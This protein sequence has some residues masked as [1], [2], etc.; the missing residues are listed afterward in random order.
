[1]RFETLS[2]LTIGLFGMGAEG[3]ATKRVLKERVP[4]A[5]LIE[6]GEESLDRLNVCDVVVKSPGVSL[7]RPELRAFLNRGGR[8]TSGSNLFFA[9]K[10]PD[11]QIIAVTGTKGKSTTA[12]LTAHTLN[13]LGI[14][15]ALGGNIGEPLLNLLEA[16]Q[17]IC[18]AELSSYQCA[19]LIHAPDMAILTNLYPEHLQWHGSH[20]RYFADKLNMVKRAKTRLV[21]AACP[22]IGAVLKNLSPC[23]TFND[24]TSFH[25]QD[26]TFYHG[27][28][29]LFPT[30]ALNLP[31]EHN[32]QNACAVL[33]VLAILSHDPKT[34]QPAFGTFQ[35]LKHRL[36]SF[37]VTGDSRTYVDDSISTTPETAI[38]GLKA[39]DQGQ[40]LTLIAGGLDRGQDYACLIDYLT[41]LRQRCLIIT[42]PQTGERL[43]QTAQAAGIPAY[44]CDTMA[45]AVTRAKQETPAGG[46]ILLSP[47]AP[48]YNMYRNFQERGLDFQRLCQQNI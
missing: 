11:M 43:N 36:Q 37:T 8:L 26:G 6:I 47:A 40:F 39:F 2:G 5:R 24:P 44:A 18:V 29:A 23:L 19:D 34:A 13:A 31:G 17:N 33:A 30:R 35:A 20:E 42:L 45:A 38:A 32:A 21:N 16:P 7:Y 46:L 12:A 1:M 48:S 25:V 22:R 9:N 27:E 28:H 41:P 3:A 4:T 15:T 10:R 14:P